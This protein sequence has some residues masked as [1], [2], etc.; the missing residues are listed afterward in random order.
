MTIY[1]IHAYDLM[2]AYFCIGFIDFMLK[3]KSLLGYINLFFPNDYE[4]NDKN[5]AKIFSITKKMKKLNCIIC[6]KCRKFEKPRI[7]YIFEKILVL[8]IICSKCKTENE[9]IVKE[10]ESIEILKIL[11]S[12]ENI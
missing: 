10:E 6:G 9:K 4:K 7:S 11:G 8:S 12:I 5:N 3:G 1:R 2:C